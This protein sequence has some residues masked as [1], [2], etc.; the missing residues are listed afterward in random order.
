MSVFW[1]L[2]EEHSYTK[3]LG[4]FVGRPDPNSSTGDYGVVVLYDNEPPKIV[5]SLQAQNVPP[6]DAQVERNKA[7][8]R[9]ATVTY[10]LVPRDVTDAH[11][12]TPEA[13]AP[14]NHQTVVGIVIGFT[15]SRVPGTERYNLR[16]QVRRTDLNVTQTDVVDGTL[17]L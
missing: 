5:T 1:E 3:N 12:L 14:T 4:E 13:A 11:S 6:Y 7:I 8:R 9:G 15:M 10:T 16:V 17:K 2:V